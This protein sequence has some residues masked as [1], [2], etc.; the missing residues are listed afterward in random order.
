[1]PIYEYR[2][3]HCGHRFERWQKMSDP[4]PERCPECKAAQIE[5][6]ISAVGFRLK[7]KGWY[8]TDFKQSHRHNIAGDGEASS[9]K[10]KSTVDGAKEKGA[11]KAAPKKESTNTDGGKKAAAPQKGDTTA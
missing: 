11:D 4:D 5:R 10:D 6:L 1:M 3:Q 9:G 2:C 7:G 8:E